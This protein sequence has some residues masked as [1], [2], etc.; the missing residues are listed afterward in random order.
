MNAQRRWS[1]LMAAACLAWLAGCARDDGPKLVPVSGTILV[2][3]QPMPSAHVTFLPTGET[4][5]TGADGKTDANGV[6]TLKARHRGAGT[7]AGTY[8]VVVSKMVKADGSDISPD[9]AT[10]PVLSGAR[11]VIPA[12]YSSHAAST[13]TATVPEEGTS[14]L[15][16]EIKTSGRR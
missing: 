4:R 9:D 10:P 7:V 6:F 14:D 13:L 2:N 16:I 15:R 5:G 8:K 1:L 12:P 3:G 11:E